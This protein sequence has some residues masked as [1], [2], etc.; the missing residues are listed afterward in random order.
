LVDSLGNDSLRDNGSS[1][2]PS[3][4]VI[5]SVAEEMSL[6]EL[7]REQILDKPELLDKSITPSP[8]SLIF[9]LPNNSTKVL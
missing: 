8:S 4:E 3:W 6:D 9:L 7:W 2:F 5:E 1:H